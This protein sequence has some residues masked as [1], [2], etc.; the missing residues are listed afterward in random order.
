MRAPALLVAIVCLLVALSGPVLGQETSLLAGRVTDDVDAIEGRDAELIAALE[1]VAERAGVVLYAFYTATTG[2]LSVT[3]YADATA[4]VNSLGGRDA[5]LVVALEDR[6]Y[7]LWVGDSLRLSDREVDTVLLRDVEPRLAAG[8][9]YGA[10]VG[11]GNGLAQALGAE[12]APTRPPAA[13]DGEAAG[14]GGI[15]AGLLLLVGLLGGGTWGWSRIQ[16]RRGAKRAVEERD[17]RTGELAREVNSRLLASD[18]AV[19]DADQ[20]LAFAEAQFREADVEPFREALTHAR[21]ELHAAF[22]ARQRLDDDIP[23]THE[24]RVALLTEIIDRTNRL[25]EVLT[26]GHAQLDE[27]RDLERTAPEVL[28]ALPARIA[29]VSQ[30]LTAAQP[31]LESVQAI[32]ADSAEAVDGNLVEAGKRVTSAQEAVLAGQEAL[33][34]AEVGSASTAAR[35]VRDAEEALAEAAVLIEG[36]EHLAESAAHAELELDATLAR[37]ATALNEARTAVSRAGAPGME[38]P[39]AEAQTLFAQADAQ[40]GGGG[41]ILAG[42]ELALGASAAA[43]RVLAEVAEAEQARARARASADAALRSAEVA[44]RRAEDY[45]AGRRRGVGREARTRLQE[46]ERHLLQAQSLLDTDEG[47]AA[48]Q[49]ARAERLANEAYRIARSDFDDYDRYQGPFGRGPYGGGWGGRGRNRTV[50]IGGFPIPMG[51]TGRGGGGWGGSTWGSPGR[52]SGGTWG[53]GGSSRGGSF[54]GSSRGGSFG[55]GGGRSRGGRF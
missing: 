34:A 25:D 24:Q 27:L 26:A 42:Y 7:A 23:E 17:R 31:L 3:D 35:F 50:V 28:A 16:A 30:Q 21:T 36:V 19:R 55:G 47:E 38:E 15:L 13:E 20:E 22:E 9:F 11:A 14:G 54:G 5:L 44:Y 48:Q 41:D 51:G 39:L 18:E 12:P 6:T 49:A 4:E 33:A 37:A 8:D 43:D 53:G 1:E 40:V 2:D 10:A 29:A 32:A 45:L 46:A 52:S